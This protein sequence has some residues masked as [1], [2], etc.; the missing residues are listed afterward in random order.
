MPRSFRRVVLLLIVFFLSTSLVADDYD[1]I[2]TVDLA[3]T[4][5]VNSNPYGIAFH[6]SEPLMYVALAG[7][8]GIV[9]PP[10]LVNGRSV[11]EIALDTLEVVRTFEVGL[12]PVDIAIAGDGSELYVTNSSSASI[13]VVNLVTGDSEEVPLEDTQGLAVEFPSGIAVSPDGSELWITSN[14]GS[15]DGSSE[16]LVILDRATRALIDTVVIDGGLGRFAVRGDGIVVMPVG[17][18]GGV[19]PSLPEVRIFD[20]TTGDPWTELDSFQ[21]DVDLADFPG[22]VGAALSPD[23]STAYVTVFGGSTDVFVVS[24]DGLDLLAPI[25]L[26]GSSFLQHGVTISGDGDSLYV[27]VFSEIFGE[28]GELL[29]I[30]LA[31]GVVEE[32]IALE[33]DPNAV[34][35]FGGRGWITNQGSSTLSVVELPGGFTRGDTDESGELA[36]IDG[37]TILNYLFLQGPLACEDTADIDDDGTLGLPDALALLQYLFSSGPAPAYPF[38][39]P[40]ADLTADGLQC[41]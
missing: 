13:S 26:G 19:F 32:S 37:I 3:G 41:Q 12:F 33:V 15:F 11:A 21:L 40:G 17:F 36:L 30:D 9:D 22:P 35:L 24:V 23:G 31:G 38:P 28:A 5:P 10:E 18:P 20:S 8:V 25:D 6:P 14:G 2:A 27:S 16:N 7:L 4:D 34:A 1:V 39:L 29:V